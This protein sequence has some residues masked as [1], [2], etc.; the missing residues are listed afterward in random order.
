MVS[1]RIAYTGTN[2]TEIYNRGVNMC[3]KEDKNGKCAIG[4]MLR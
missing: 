2:T 1:D 3:G 4:A